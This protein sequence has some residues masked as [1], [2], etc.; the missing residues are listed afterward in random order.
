MIPYFIC[1]GAQKAGTSW[2]GQ[3]LKPTN[4]TKDRKERGI[5]I[6][7]IAIGRSGLIVK[8]ENCLNEIERTM[9]IVV[10]I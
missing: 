2:L 7:R 9:G 4:V 6:K 5:L 8:I 3:N 1:I 10:K